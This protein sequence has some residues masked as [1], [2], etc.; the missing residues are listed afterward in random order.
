[1]GPSGLTILMKHRT[2][3]FAPLNDW[4]DDQEGV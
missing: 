3:G 1:M 2:L 4:S